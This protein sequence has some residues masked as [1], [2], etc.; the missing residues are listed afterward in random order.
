MEYPPPPSP[1]K[2]APAVNLRSLFAESKMPEAPSGAFK[3]GAATAAAPSAAEEGAGK[4]KRE[5]YVGAATLSKKQALRITDATDLLLTK[6]KEE[7]DA[8]GIDAVAIVQNLRASNDPEVMLFGIEQLHNALHT[9][10][11]PPPSRPTPNAL[12]P[13]RPRGPSTPL[14]PP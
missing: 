11:R 12:P 3:F 9:K 1:P 8:K 4:R 13:R 10:A 7:R 6:Q 2:G 14:D 5:N